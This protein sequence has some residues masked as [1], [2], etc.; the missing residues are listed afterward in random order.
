MKRIV[1]LAVITMGLI[2]NMN[3]AF[4][5]DNSKRIKELQQEA[6]MLLDERQKHLS[7]ITRIEVR[8][9]EINGA[10]KELSPKEPG[11]GMPKD[12]V[13]K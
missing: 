2:L 8:L 11:A 5:E 9:Y 3:L 10:L 6:Q 7:E 13:K 12:S 4:A 1:S